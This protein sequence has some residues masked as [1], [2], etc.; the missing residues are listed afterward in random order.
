MCDALATTREHAPAKSF[1]PEK[2]RLNLITVPACP[3]HNLEN[4]EDVEYVRNVI[5]GQRGTNELAAQV[6]AT[7]KRS[8]EHSPALFTQTF[9]NV[10][11]VVI[12]GQETGAFPI[13]LPRHRMVMRAI[14]N[15]LYYHDKG[16]RHDGGFGVFSPS[17]AHRDNLYYGRP[18]PAHGLRRY[19]E[20]GAFTA[21]P[22]SNPQVFQ[23]AALDLG[24]GQLL[25]RLVF[26]ELHCS[27]LDATVQSEPLSLSSDGQCVGLFRRLSASR[28]ANQAA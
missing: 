17:M 4:A 11:T 8:Y 3:L 25:Y 27:H 15:A 19:L 6:F 22:V 1:F 13:D 10:R 21:M 16:K 26:Y 5:C 23:Y 20:S 14:G 2:Y 12:D 18:D 7:A 24:E 9:A 28:F